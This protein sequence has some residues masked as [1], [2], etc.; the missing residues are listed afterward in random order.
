MV[1]VSKSGRFILCYNI[2]F[3]EASSVHYDELLQLQNTTS[4]ASASGT[5]ASQIPLLSCLKAV[6]RNIIKTRGRTNKNMQQWK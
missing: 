3:T 6:E 2:V 4:E 1:R 5:S